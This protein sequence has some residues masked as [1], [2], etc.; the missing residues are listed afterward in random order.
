MTE[1]GAEKKRRIEALLTTQDVSRILGV[2][3]T[4]V[5]NLVKRGELQ[6]HRISVAGRDVENSKA[7]LYFTKNDLREYVN[8]RWGKKKNIED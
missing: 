2:S 3:Y 4:T 5:I 1:Q 8:W 6:A 7:K